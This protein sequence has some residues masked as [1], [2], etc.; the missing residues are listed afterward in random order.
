MQIQDRINHL[1]NL[2][3]KVPI[4]KTFKLQKELVE[5]EKQLKAINETNRSE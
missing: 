2:I 4:R 3:T 1:K 5:L